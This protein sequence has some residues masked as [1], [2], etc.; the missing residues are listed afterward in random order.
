MQLVI[1]CNYVDHVC[2]YKIDIIYYMGYIVVCA[3]TMHENKKHL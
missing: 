1:I 2:N 3:T